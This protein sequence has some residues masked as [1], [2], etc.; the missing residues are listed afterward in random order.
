MGHRASK[1]S[2]DAPELEHK[3]NRALLRHLRD[4]VNVTAGGH[5]PSNEYAN[6]TSHVLR[7]IERRFVRN[8]SFK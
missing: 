3:T 6:E 2:D 5:T 7:E 4:Y 8:S 1:Y